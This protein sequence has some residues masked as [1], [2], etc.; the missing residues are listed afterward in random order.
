MHVYVF[1]QQ[2]ADPFMLELQNIQPS[3]GVLPEG[4]FAIVV[5]GGPGSGKGTLCA[6]LAEKFD[7]FHISSGDLL[8][9]EVASGSRLGAACSSLMAQGKLLPPEVGCTM[10]RNA[11]LQS[12][13]HRFLLDG[14]PRSVEQALAFG[15]QVMRI[16][17]CVFLDCS[18]EIMLQRLLARGQATGRADD[19]SEATICKRFTTFKTDTHPVV[20]MFQA[21]GT[22]VSVLSGEESVRDVFL[23][24]C[25][26]V[27]QALTAAAVI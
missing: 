14:F 24:A 10:I 25:A 6:Q 4:A 8:R 9:A 21:Q 23:G 22:P 1:W 12:K 13:Q 3:S 7:M 18:E 15:A 20:A 5:L 11:M 2:V 17:L 27:E 26:A 19:R 16:S